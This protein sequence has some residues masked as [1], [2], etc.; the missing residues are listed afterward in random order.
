[1][2]PDYVLQSQQNRPCLS[3]LFFL[4]FQLADKTAAFRPILCFYFALY[5]LA[6][7]FLNNFD[8]EVA[9][10]S[11]YFEKHRDLEMVRYRFKFK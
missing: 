4:V 9:Y 8:S 2:C 6:I 10:S 3:S 7:V 1:V 5:R 11:Q